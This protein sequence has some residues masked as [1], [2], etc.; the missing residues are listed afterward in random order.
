MAGKKRLEGADA[1]TVAA[2]YGLGG[3]VPDYLQFTQLWLNAD[4]QLAKRAFYT[5]VAALV[6]NGES[7]PDDWIAA[8]VPNPI[9]ASQWRRFD[10]K[11]HR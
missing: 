5:A 9:E 1:A 7:I 4:H 8:A 3:A 10:L 6:G 2:V 11:R